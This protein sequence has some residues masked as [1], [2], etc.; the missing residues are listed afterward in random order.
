MSQTVKDIACA[1]RRADRSE[2]EVFERSLAA[3][4]RKGVRTALERARVR[5][6]MEEAEQRRVAALYAFEAGLAESRGARIVV[7]LDEVGRGPL[8]G[9]LAVGAVALG[10]EII[11]G[12]NDSKQLKSEQ[13]EC[14]AEHIKATARAWTVQYVDPA[15]I[16][17]H[18]MTASLV[19]VFQRAI[20]EIERCGINPDLVLLDGNPLNMDAREVNVVK[21]DA[22]CASIAAASVVAKVERDRLM[23]RYAQEYP[24]YHFDECKGYASPAHIEAIRR[25]GLTPIHRASFCTAFTQESLF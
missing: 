15:F 1:L 17:A 13:R 3:D 24:A 10:P 20:R 4:T 21:G 2:L 6:E 5:I 11:E 22:K 23:Q 8:A 12:L 7:G 25:F 9:P 19:E 18:G 14:V 16:D